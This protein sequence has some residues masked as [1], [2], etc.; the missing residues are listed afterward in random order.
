[1]NP[2]LGFIL[3]KNMG[4][5]VGEIDLQERSTKKIK[6]VTLDG[7]MVTR[8][9]TLGM[10]KSYRDILIGSSIIPYI[11]MEVEE[12]LFEGNHQEEGGGM[13]IL[14]Y[15]V[16]EYDCPTFVLFELWEKMIHRP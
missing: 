11:N 10:N 8:E 15:K 3:P 13:K 2:L 12:E 9:S 1:M 7:M 5:S 16:G 14:E 4:K 6:D